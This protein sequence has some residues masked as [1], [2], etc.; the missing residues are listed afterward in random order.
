MKK[1][2]TAGAMVLVLTGAVPA[3]DPEPEYPN[4][5]NC[6]AALVG[7]AQATY[8]LGLCRQGIIL[9]CYVYEMAVMQAQIL[10][11]IHCHMEG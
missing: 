3:E 6:T 11:G 8:L 7:Y 10:V 2:L 1:L 5:D 9:D 4:M